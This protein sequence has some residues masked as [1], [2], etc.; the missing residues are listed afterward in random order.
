MARAISRLRNL[1]KPIFPTKCQTR[2]HSLLIPKRNG[3]KGHPRIRLYRDGRYLKPL[4]PSFDL[5][6]FNLSLV[7]RAPR[8]SQPAY[9]PIPRGLSR[10][11]GLEF[12]TV[13]DQIAGMLRSDNG[14]WPCRRGFSCRVSYRDLTLSVPLYIPLPPSLS[15]PLPLSISLPPLSPSES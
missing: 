11:V 2:T 5:L 12:G 6:K 1:E 15:L 13:I 3:L 7:R 8:A 14:S 9:G 4:V 10:P